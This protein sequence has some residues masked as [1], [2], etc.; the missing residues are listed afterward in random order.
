MKSAHFDVVGGAAGDMLLAALID[1]GAPPDAIREGLATLPVPE[2]RLV[3]DEVRSGGMRASRVTLQ[4]PDEKNHRHLPQVLEVLR[5]GRLPESVVADAERVFG[6]LAEAEARSHGIPMEKVHFHE[7]GA[8]DAILDIAGVCLALYLLQ[9]RDVTFSPLGVGTGEVDTAHGRIPVPVPAVL[10]LTKGFPI[11]RTEIRGEILTPT[12][13]ALVTTL[14]RPVS[15]DAFVAESVGVGAGHREIPGRPNVLRVSLGAREATAWD[16]DEVTLLETNLDDMSPEALPVVLA[17]LMEAGARDAYLTPILMKKGRP[18]YVLSALADPDR[19]RALAEVIFRETSTFGVRRRT[20][21][22]WVLPRETRELESPWGPVRI[23]I[24]D[25][26]DGTRRVT[27]EFESCREIA[28]RTG[29]PLLEVYR[30]VDGL[31]R[32][33]EL[34]STAG[35]ASPSES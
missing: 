12:G 21:A 1:A 2:F 26:G 18:G 25:L 32:S 31:I 4:V 35:P 24:G 23:K 20:V 29:T 13:A 19:A 27:P 16:I 9:V 28:E 17:R 34:V 14:G 3:V 30:Q 5:G 6:R 33:S 15:T 10:E 8:L 7:V 22:R 11:V